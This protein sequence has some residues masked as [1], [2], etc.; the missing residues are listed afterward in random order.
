MFF[1]FHNNINQILYLHTLTPYIN[2]KLRLLFTDSKY[3]LTQKTNKNQAENWSCFTVK[4]LIEVQ[5]KEQPKEKNICSQSWILK[6]QN[7]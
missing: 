7:Q 2:T 3:N 6:Q 4:I 5:K 1:F